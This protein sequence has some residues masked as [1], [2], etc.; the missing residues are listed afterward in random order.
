MSNLANTT[1]GIIGGG[2]LAKMLAQAAIDMSL[3]LNFWLD[4]NE[5]IV[6]Q[7]GTTY[8][9]PKNSFD[10]FCHQS[11][12]IIFEHEHVHLNYL[13][14]LKNSFQHKC[15]ALGLLLATQNR[16]LEKDLFAALS[17]PCAKPINLDAPTIDDFPMVLK[18]RVGGYDGKGQYIVSNATELKTAL[19]DISADLFIAEQFVAFQKECSLVCVRSQQGDFCAYD[20]TENKNQSGMLAVSHNIKE[21][22]LYTQAFEYCQRIAQ[23]TR[24]VGVF[25][26]EFFI[27]SDN[28][29][30]ANEISP[31]VHNSGHWT[32][33]GAFVSQFEN[34]IR[35]SLGI[36]IGNVKS[37]SNIRMT[38]IT[39][40]KQ[41]DNAYQLDSTAKLYLYG[42]R[43]RE[44]RKMGHINELINA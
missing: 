39:T 30:I 31:R 25:A 37:H 4:A 32:M 6:N 3:K 7:L 36:A 12:I 10:E 23:E 8:Q 43:P 19:D 38:N 35:A 21:S 34:H 2:Q 28:D 17:I 29:L 16:Q 1:I 13:D 27:T 41:L 26:V 9:E 11:D 5:S 20:L 40:L 15:P 24:Y 14:C 22:S 42:K 44:G 18:K 33:D